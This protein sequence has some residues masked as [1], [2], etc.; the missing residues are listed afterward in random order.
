MSVQ[1][2][3][4]TNWE[5]N[6][7][8]LDTDLNKWETGINDC[9][10]ELNNNTVK[11]DASTPFTM[12]QL[13]VDPV[14]PRGLT[15]LQKVNSLLISA[16]TSN[17]P[18]LANNP[19]NPNTQI[20]FGTGFCYDLVTGSKIINTAITK[21]LDAT[22]VAGT[23]NGGLDTGTKAINT[24]Y[25]CFS[26]AKED[27]TSDFLFSTN[28]SSP[29]MPSGYIYKRRI[30][31][32]K[33]AGNGNI[34]GF[35]QNGDRFSWKIPVRDVF[36]AQASNSLPTTALLKTMSAP[37]GVET[38]VMIYAL[39]FSNGVAINGYISSPNITDCDSSELGAFNL[40]SSTPGG[41][42]QNGS[43]NL[44]IE[45]NTSSQIRFRFT[46]SNCGFYT[47]TQG[48]IDKRGKN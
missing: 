25:H 20:D 3:A 12:E 29:T 7:K 16:D 13:G 5:L 38:V 14:S 32:I 2:N 41:Y 26:I 40:C 18:T 8:V 31:S 37:F 43:A 19:T 39:L 4:K 46:S 47:N 30:G 44:F 1:Y 48:Y 33:T 35:Y 45:T 22:F 34:L 23:G 15:T 28:V 6:E 42:Q 24:W 9:V 17:M 11:L 10:N 36:Y 21:K 27:G